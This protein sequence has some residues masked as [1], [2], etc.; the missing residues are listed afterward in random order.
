MKITHN[1]VGQNLNMVDGA[2]QDKTDAARSVKDAKTNALNSPS[3]GLPD[4]GDATKVD[5]SDRAQEAKRIKDLAK[6]APDVDMQK[7]EKFR[8]MIDNGTYKVDARAVADRMVDD[9]L[10]EDRMQTKN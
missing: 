4:K 3:A 10:A 7:V 5:V 8:Q 1:K 9:A 2:R 6:A